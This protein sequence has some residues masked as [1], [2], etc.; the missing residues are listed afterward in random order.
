[1][2]RKALA[3]KNSSF[4]FLCQIATLV[5]Q[6]A[7][8]K[9]FI[10]YIGVELLGISS[11]FSSILN[12]LSLAELGFNR[13]IVY[14][15]YKPLAEK[16]KERINDIICVLR[17]MYTALGCFILAAGILCC[18]LLPYLL[19]D[20]EVDGYITILFLLSV[21]SSAVSYLG[22]TR[23]T[24][25]YADQHSY[26]TKLIGIGSNLVFLIIR[27]TV[28]ILTQ[29][30]L[31]CVLLSLVQ[32]ISVNILIL[33]LD[34]KYHPYLVRTKFKRS[35]FLEAWASAKD[36]FANK[37]A[38]Y[39]YNS[40]DALVLSAVIGTKS[41]GYLANY[42][43]VTV[44][45]KGL[46]QSIVAPVAPLIGNLM[47]EDGDTVKHERVLHM[48]SYIRF[49]IAGVFVLPLLV[50]L[51]SFIS[52]WIGD[53]YLLSDAV[54]M[55]CCADL[56]IHFVHSALCDYITAGGLFAQDKRI[57]IMGA[58]TNL[59]ISVALVFSMGIEGVLIGT[60]ISQVF[61][62]IQ[63]SIVVYRH[64]FSGNSKGLQRYWRRQ[65]EYVALFSVL[66]ILLKLG[67]RALDTMFFP[68]RFAAGGILCEI[69]FLTFT[70]LLFGRREEHRKVKQM[71]LCANRGKNRIDMTMRK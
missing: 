40:T 12:T 13:A 56:Y 46:G 68:I 64:C 35:V 26:V 60:V 71:L 15:L 69:T 41:V 5:L 66:A 10:Q 3:I 19:K 33:L 51:Q 6:F 42:R 65:I 11:T 49:L 27:I 29:E 38:G 48:Y 47:A 20:I 14:L 31:L 28:I 1:M 55:L 61:F 36:I 23:R 44:A 50:L 16:N 17:R 54:V 67:Y 18:P 2:N 39:V 62:W 22:A 7:S 53:D 32:T 4:G 45:I 30:Y 8:R 70:I 24:L 9:F 21:L 59:A 43:T 57:E 63:R 58:C 52:A 37:I 34:R 25:L